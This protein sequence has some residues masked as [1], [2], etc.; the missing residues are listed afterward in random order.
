MGYISDWHYHKKIALAV[1]KNKVVAD[2]SSDPSNQARERNKDNGEIISLIGL[3]S[4]EKNP[5]ICHF[6][7]KKKLYFCV[8][9]GIFLLPGMSE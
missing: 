7:G 8:V 2:L 9:L 5:K 3:N 6:F 1:L 4:Y